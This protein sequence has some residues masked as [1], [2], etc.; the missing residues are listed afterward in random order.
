MNEQS[1][2]QYLMCLNKGDGMVRVQWSQYRLYNR[3]VAVGLAENGFVYFRMRILVG[4]KN[5]RTTEF[6]LSP[7]AFFAL[8]GLMSEVRLNFATE[9]SK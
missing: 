8:Y 4:W 1:K 5:V 9:E 7:E 6:S 3:R 2:Q